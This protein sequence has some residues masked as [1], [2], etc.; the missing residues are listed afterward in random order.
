MDAQGCATAASTDAMLAPDAVPA[1]DV[2]VLIPTLRRPREL[3]RAL[4][5][6]L[7]Q[8][9][10][11]RIAAVVVVDNSPEASARAVVETLASETPL[12]LVYVHE[13]RPGIATARNAG[14]ACS[15]AP[16]IAFIDDDEAAP[17]QWLERLREAHLS[18]G[19]TVTF[20]PIQGIATGADPVLRPYLD[21]FFSR[22]HGGGTRLID[23]HYGCGNSMMTRAEAL[24]GPAPFDLAADRRGGEDNLLF[25]QLRIRGGRFGWAAEAELTEYA[26]PQ[27]ANLRYALRRAFCYGQGPSQGCARRGRPF[28]VAFWMAVGAGQVVVYGAAAAGAALT[29]RRLA[30]IRLFDRA[31][32]GLGKMMWPLAVP[33][34][35]LPAVTGEA[36]TGTSAAPSARG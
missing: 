2:D 29:G 22:R 15:R 24:V 31:V 13:P 27:R 36:A 21:A 25:D 23:E 26:P 34:Y 4:R 16:Y 6:V 35:G 1:R 20:G 18:L 8:D 11:R 17:P 12:R 7:A 30:A 33:L 9:A 14:L 19:A 32:R 3:E 5:S 28:G 10:H